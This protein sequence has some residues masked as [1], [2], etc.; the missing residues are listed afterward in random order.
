MNV[1]VLAKFSRSADKSAFWQ[2]YVKAYTANGYGH[3]ISLE[4]QT[5]FPSLGV[6]QITETFRPNQVWLRGI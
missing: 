2:A 5:F 6:N 4:A 1:M 3:V